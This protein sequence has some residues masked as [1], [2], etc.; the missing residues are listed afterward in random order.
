M[1]DRYVNSKFCNFYHFITVE[2]SGLAPLVDLVAAPLVDL[3]AAPLDEAA[4][5]PDEVAAHPVKLL[6]GGDQLFTWNKQSKNNIKIHRPEHI[7]GLAKL[8][9]RSLNVLVSIRRGPV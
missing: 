6:S 1:H 2:A 7:Q 3:V 5:S 9:H 4:A 8:K